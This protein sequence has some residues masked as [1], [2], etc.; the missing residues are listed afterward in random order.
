MTPPVSR[1]EPS[2]RLRALFEHLRTHLPEVS[3]RWPGEKTFEIVIGAILVQN[4]TWVNTTRSIANLR[5]QHRLEAEPLLA[6][7]PAELQALIRPSGFATAKARY[8]RSAARWFLTHG[9][10][11][12]DLPTDQLRRELLAVPGLGP[13]TADVL[14][15]NVFERP[16]FIWDTY[17]RRI[18][19]ATGIGE[20]TNYEQA[21]RVLGPA[22]DAAGLTAVQHQHF[23]ALILEA[24]KRL[25]R[26]EAGFLR[27]F[28]QLA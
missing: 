3:P 21:R 13:E 28:R 24:G 26:G 1:P 17:S 9:A 10:S 12:H 14:C 18:F 4:T 6:L 27:E 23:H 7:E 11:A 16:V 8:L 5:A 25:R 15:L 19:A 2:D 22:M 20:F